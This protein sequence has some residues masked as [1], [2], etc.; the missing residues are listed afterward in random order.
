M[1]SVVDFVLSYLTEVKLMILDAMKMKRIVS[2]TTLFYLR[3]L[4][5]LPPE[6][7]VLLGIGSQREG[8]RNFT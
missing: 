3:K 2:S 4:K 1:F 5:N 6:V 7:F 8:L